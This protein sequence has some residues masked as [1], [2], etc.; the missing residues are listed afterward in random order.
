MK[1]H[2]IALSLALGFTAASAYTLAEDAVAPGS[3][4]APAASPLASAS[5][6]QL[7][8]A[9]KKALD[10]SGFQFEGY[11]RSGFYGGGKDEP[12]AQYQL[13]GDL[14]HFRLGNEGDTYGEFGIGKK[15]TTSGGASWGVYVMPTFYSYNPVI[16]DSGSSS[17]TSAAQLYAYLSGLDFAPELTFWAGQRYHRIQDI[18][19][20]DNWLMQD[21]DNYGAGVDGIHLGQ[22]ARLNLSASTSGSYGNDN[23]QLNNARRV[24]FQLTGIPLNP[25]G[26]LTLTGGV[27]SGDFAIGKAGSAWG[28]LHKQQDFLVKGLN[29]SLFLQTSDGHASLSGEFYNLD[30]NG[31]AQAGARQHRIAEVINWQLGRFGGQALAGYQSVAPDNAP[32]YKDFS[33]GG[34]LSYGV[35]ANVKLLAEGA[36]TGRKVDNADTQRLDKVTLAV[37]FSPDTAFWSRPEFRLYVSHFNWNNAAAA[38]N[39]SSFGVGGRTRATTYGAQIEAWW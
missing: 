10:D 30:N 2:L 17:K 23:A 19:I 9:M 33:L 4:P 25:G 8:E 15:W 38:A 28:L 6:A 27:I 21:G 7:A 35:A 31:A 22:N 12:R 3:A 20:V 29:N 36:V 16:G 32:H 34:R 26:T 39:L 18:H 11:L 37:A 14:Q 24:N 5:A 13:G 1:Q